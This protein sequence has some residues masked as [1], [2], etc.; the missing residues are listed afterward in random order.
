M[1]KRLMV[2]DLICYGAFPFL[3]W[4]YGREPLGD[5][6]AILL[7][8]V[9]GFI[10]T[11]YRFVKEKQLNIAG[12]F[13]ITSLLISTAVNLL[14][15]SASN[16]LWNQ[17]YLGFGFGMVFLITTIIRKPLALYLAVDV[18]YLQGYPREDS[19]RLYK[20]KGLFLWFQLINLLFVFRALFLNSLKAYL[21]QS[22]GADGYG[23]VIIYMNISGWVFSGLIFLAF[24][25]VSNK[26]MQYLEHL[27]NEKKESSASTDA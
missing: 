23:K 11:V 8:T 19:R 14:S 2:L 15:T 4:N 27:G 7:S 10:Y 24:L 18:A 16:M 20:S 3:I 21:V 17:V 25:F 9:P 12:L 26:I 13:I 1:N 5:Y 22:Y 6:L